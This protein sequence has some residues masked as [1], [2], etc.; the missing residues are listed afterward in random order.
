MGNPNPKQM[1]AGLIA[2]AQVVMGSLAKAASNPAA[3]A[4]SRDPTILPAFGLNWNREVALSV[5]PDNA[6]NKLL[7]RLRN[8]PP[9][10][11]RYDRL[12]NLFRAA[13]LDPYSLLPE[14]A[15]WRRLADTYLLGRRYP[16]GEIA[17][18]VTLFAA[19]GVSDPGA[20][21][22]LEDGAVETIAE[23]KTFADTMRTMWR[24]SR[25]S[26]ADLSSNEHLA[27]PV[28]GLPAES[29]TKA[30]KSAFGR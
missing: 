16:H 18:A 25:N 20:L 11:L 26:K 24:I 5:N 14:W 8:S 21:A 15:E 1:N 9:P 4:R 6:I 13:Y 10:R 22:T 2:A 28:N 3:T 29:S 19:W 30:E 7:S 27:L 23:T 17:H 12:A